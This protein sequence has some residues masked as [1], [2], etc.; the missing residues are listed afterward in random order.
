VTENGEKII[1]V[2]GT[3]GAIGLATGIARGIV[4]S[5]HDGWA[6]FFRGMIASVTAAVLIGWSLSDFGFTPTTFAA[7]VGV[8]AFLADDVLLGLQEVGKLF[9]ADPIGTIQ[10]VWAAIRGQAKP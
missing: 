2:A 7:I 10:R 6:S 1:A 5:R 4:Q 3:A 8:C 9:G